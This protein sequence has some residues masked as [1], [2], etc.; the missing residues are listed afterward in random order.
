MDLAEIKAEIDKL[1]QMDTNYTNCSKLAILYSVYDRNTKGDTPGNARGY[2]YAA[3]EFLNAAYN[4]PLDGVLA[5]IDEHME[6]INAI[7][8]KEYRAIINRIKDL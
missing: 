3:S 4:A 7:Y 1:E 5:I 2:S 8:P 6:C